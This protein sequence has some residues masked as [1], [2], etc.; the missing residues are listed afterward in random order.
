MHILD[1]TNNSTFY[2][3]QPFIRKTLNFSANYVNI[4]YIIEYW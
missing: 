2:S 3:K 1:T 4:V